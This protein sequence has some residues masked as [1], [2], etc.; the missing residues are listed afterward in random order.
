M[1]Y[2]IGQINKM[3]AYCLKVMPKKQT[4]GNTMQ[5]MH[6]LTVREGAHVPKG[7][8]SVRGS[9]NNKSARV[10]GNSNHMST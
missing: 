6:G 2:H 4:F 9:G 7:P 3:S 1:C 5:F 8:L 10:R